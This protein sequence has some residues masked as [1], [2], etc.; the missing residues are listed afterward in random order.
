MRAPKFA[1]GDRVRLNSD[2]HE[3]SSR[4]GIVV[5][6]IEMDMW[7]Y[8]VFIGHTLP[9]RCREDQ[10]VA[11]DLCQSGVPSPREEYVALIAAWHRNAS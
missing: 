6:A 7:R 4:E 8:D 11:A 3:F 10:I 9:V 2:V 1:V 5:K